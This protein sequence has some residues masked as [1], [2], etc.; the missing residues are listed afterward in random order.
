MNRSEKNLHEGH[1]FGHP[2]EPRDRGG[3]NG[4]DDRRDQKTRDKRCHHAGCNVLSS[5]ILHLDQRGRD[6]NAARHFGQC[7]NGQSGADKAELARHKQ[8]ARTVRTRILKT[9]SAPFPPDIHRKFRK[10]RLV[11]EPSL[12]P[13]KSGSGVPGGGGVFCPPVI[14]RHA[15]QRS[16]QGR[17]P[18]GAP[19]MGLNGS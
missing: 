4:I 13:D 5:K 16:A 15:V 9:A 18:P 14:N 3:G 19:Q 10:V 11:R 6:T 12:S 7:H 2:I 17:D 8:R 1:Q